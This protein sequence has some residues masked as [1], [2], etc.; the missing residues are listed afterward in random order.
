MVGADEVQLYRRIPAVHELLE[1]PAVRQ[2]LQ[3]ASRDF[4]VEVIGETLEGLREEIRNGGIGEKE[5]DSALELLDR[6]VEARLR[7]RLAASLVRVVNATG[8]V[9]FT[10]LG[11]APL[12]DFAI[13]EAFDAAVSYTNLEFDLKEGRRGH[14]DQHLEPALRRLLNCEA[15]TVCN[16]AAAAVLLIL[17][18]LAEGREV[19]IS[20]GELIEIG[21]SFRIP[22]ILDKSGARLREVGTTNKTRLDDYRS[23]LTSDTGLILR[24]HPSNYRIT[25]FTHSPAIEELVGFA[26]ES[27]VP[28]AYDLGS[29][30]LFRTGLPF[31]DREPTVQD[32]ISAGVDL[33]CFSGD[34]LLGGPQAGLILGGGE[35]IDRIRR[36]PMMRTMRVDKI[37]YA[38]LASTLREYEKGV[39][40]STIP[41]WRMLSAAYAD[42]EQ[43]ATKIS[44][45]LQILDFQA[46]IQRGLSLPGG[47]SAPEEGIP[48]PLVRIRHAERSAAEIQEELRRGQTPVIG[49]IERDHFILDLRTV[50]P[51]QDVA[52]VGAFRALSGNS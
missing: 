34:K 25:G 29:G 48:S 24:V 27:G 5:L 46:E 22:A 51:E 42:L 7:H 30:C 4:L 32:S 35:W 1:R 23:A 36:N 39:Y 33:V 21:G 2:L 31:L 15:A 50:F 10:N 49:R 8:V 52:I 11:R 40:Q 19:L 45:A 44:S 47:G 26:R 43:R 28:L 13:K 9:I 20:R 12:A 38:V 17:N 14:R 3:C 6:Q 18:T 37:I 16:N 41:V